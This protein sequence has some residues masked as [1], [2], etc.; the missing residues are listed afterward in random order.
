M[1]S[2]ESDAD[3]QFHAVR[4]L[5]EFSSSD[6]QSALRNAAENRRIALSTQEEAIFRLGQRGNNGDFLRTLF[7]RVSVE[8]DGSLRDSLQRRVMFSLS[9]RADATTRAWLLELSADM[10]KTI[11]LRRYAIFAA[12]EAKVPSQNIA[13]LYDRQ[14]E[15]ELKQQSIDVLGG[16]R[17][18]V[19]VARIEQIIRTDPNLWA[20]RRAEYWVDR[21]AARTSS[22]TPPP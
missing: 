17:D 18:S 20:R 6:A 11:Q 22:K 4:S 14:S 21:K 1:V 2:P 10:D 9:Q 3:L 13:A 16:R 5:A 19:A 7:D 15:V 12:G 8:R